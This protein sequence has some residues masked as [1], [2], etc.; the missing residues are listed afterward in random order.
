MLE[1]LAKDWE[2]TFPDTWNLY[3]IS[4]EKFRE[5]RTIRIK[6]KNVDD[7]DL[8]K[9]GSLVKQANEKSSKANLKNLF[10]SLKRS[11]PNSPQSTKQNG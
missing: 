2:E 11:S 10:K 6:G 1:T 7:L 4:L 9:V 3:R 8:E 5:T